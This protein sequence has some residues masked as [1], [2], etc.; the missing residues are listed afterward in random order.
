M[1]PSGGCKVIELA[2]S[3]AQTPA[4]RYRE[5]NNPFSM[6]GPRQSTELGRYAKRLDRLPE[7]PTGPIAQFERVPRC[8]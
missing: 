8:K 1:Q 3:E 7:G 2:V 4:D 5:R 6:S